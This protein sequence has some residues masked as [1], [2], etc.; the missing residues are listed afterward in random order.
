LGGVRRDKRKKRVMFDWYDSTVKGWLRRN[1]R[2]SKKKIREVRKKGKRGGLL[3]APIP[4][5]PK[6]RPQREGRRG[7]NIMVT[8]MGVFSG[9][10][11]GCGMGRKSRGRTFLQGG[12][13]ED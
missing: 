13:R 11:R 2:N 1:L 7:K 4:G 5:L 9:G 12:G 8:R 3:L 10:E 6:R